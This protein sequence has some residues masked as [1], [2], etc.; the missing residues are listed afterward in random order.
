MA[1]GRRRYGGRRRRMGRRRRR[2]NDV[3][4]RRNIGHRV[5]TTTTKAFQTVQ[6]AD[7]FSSRDLQQHNMTL[8]PKTTTN[9]VNERQRNIANIRGFK[10][11]LQLENLG[12]IHLTLNIAVISP[13]D[14]RATVIPTNDFFRDPTSDDRAVAF[15]DSRSNQQMSKYG[16]NPDLYTVLRHKRYYLNA[17]TLTEANTFGT[18][19]NT[20]EAGFETQY[21]QLQRTKGASFKNF[22]WWVPLKR[23]LRWTGGSG[24]TESRSKVWLV[25]WV[26]EFGADTG[27]LAITNACSRDLRV[28]TFF[29]EPKP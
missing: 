15:S 13:K 10:I 22:E 2:N 4:S 26:D 14:T 5:G 12:Q 23:Q 25:Y 7:T 11:Y 20:D 21:P 9:D 27:S 17:L 6:V 1:Y 16:I 24:N 19:T 3:W 8:I 29:R 18:G 28:H